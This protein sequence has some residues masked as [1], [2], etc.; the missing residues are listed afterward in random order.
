MAILR[1]VIFGE[2]FQIGALDHRTR[3]LITVVVLDESD[4]AAASVTY[5]SRPQR[6]CCPD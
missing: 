3:E 6:G 5:G 2:V 1:Q 4:L